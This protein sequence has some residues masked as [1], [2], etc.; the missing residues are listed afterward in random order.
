[1][2]DAVVQGL[3]HYF[4]VVLLQ[5]NGHELVEGLETEPEISNPGEDL[6]DCQ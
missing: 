3:Q 2:G 1:M 5:L 4:G 6:V